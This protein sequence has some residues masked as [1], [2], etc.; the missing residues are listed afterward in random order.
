MAL[1]V[2]PR[3]TDP[4]AVQKPGS[5]L[6]P[7]P[8][9]VI[10]VAVAQGDTV[11]AGQPLIW[12]EAMKMEH[13][14][15]APADGIVETLAVVRGQ[16]LS[17]GDVLAVITEATE[18]NHV[19]AFTET[20]EHR[21]LRAA[22]AALA[23]KYGQDYFRGR[24]P[25]RPQDRRTMGRGRQTRIHRVNLPEEYGG[26]GAGMYELSIVMEEIAAAGTGLLMLVVSPAIC[27]NI[28]VR[29]G[30]DEQ[31]QRWVPGLADGSYV[32]AFGITE[33][34]AGSNSH[35]ITTTAHRDGS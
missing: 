14:I 33:P 12:L 21:E 28:I 15:T 18:G 20:D 11:A 24:A 8:G 9:S 26:G 6:A 34:D 10:R 7:M 27:G 25:E 30:T 1:R 4:S 3:F 22:V 31:K 32:M 29:F 23:T 35:C 19:S 17:V 13:T 5:L 16:Q 2:V